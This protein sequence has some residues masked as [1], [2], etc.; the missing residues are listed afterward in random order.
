MLW[1][2]LRPSKMVCYDHRRLHI[3]LPHI[4]CLYNPFQYCPILGRRVEGP[5]WYINYINCS[6][7]SCPI[8]GKSSTG[9]AWY[10]NCELYH[11]PII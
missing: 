9:P 11:L 10:I 5:A 4:N 1:I 8:L 6:L 7:S 2:I 3:W